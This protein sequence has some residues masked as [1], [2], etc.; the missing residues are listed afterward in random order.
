MFLDLSW[1]CCW[2][3]VQADILPWAGEQL[4]GERFLFHLEMNFFRVHPFPPST[5]EMLT[6]ATGPG[7][8]TLAF[9]PLLLPW[10]RAVIRIKLQVKREKADVSLSSCQFSTLEWPVVLSPSQPAALPWE[11]NLWLAWGQLGVINTPSSHGPQ[12]GG[13]S[14]SPTPPSIL[15]G[16]SPP[17]EQISFFIW[18]ERHVSECFEPFLVI[19]CAAQGVD[20]VLCVFLVYTW[21]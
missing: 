13:V 10:N 6:C 1:I 3:D 21:G 17:R 4:P 7:I 19:F 2:S 5:K 8:W 12:G 9:L 16:H 15:L 14:L 18:L 20:S 11:G